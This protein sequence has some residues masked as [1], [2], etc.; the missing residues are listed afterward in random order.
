MNAGSVDCPLETKLGPDREAAA[1]SRYR[2]EHA[3]RFAQFGD[4]SGALHEAREAL[5]LNPFLWFARMFLVQCLVHEQETKRAAREFATLLEL[6]LD[7]RDSLE[8]WFAAERRRW[9]A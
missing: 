4:S 8:Q 2:A 9:K 7:Q 3:L 6:H 5:R 1:K